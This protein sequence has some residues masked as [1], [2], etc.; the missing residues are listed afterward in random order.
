MPLQSSIANNFII[1]VLRKKDLHVWVTIGWK[2]ILW[3]Q[4]HF[5][6]NFENE[7]HKSQQG[8]YNATEIEVTGKLSPRI[9]IF[10]FSSFYEAM[11]DKWSIKWYIVFSYFQKKVF[12][13]SF[14]N[15]AFLSKC[16]CAGSC[17]L[18]FRMTGL[19]RFNDKFELFVFLKIHFIIMDF[20]WKGTN[21]AQKKAFLAGKEIDC[22]T[23]AF[24][25]DLFSCE[26]LSDG[27][28]SRL[29]LQIRT[30]GSIL[31][32]YSLFSDYCQM[33]IDRRQIEWPEKNFVFVT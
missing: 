10:L 32:S 27:L 1:L 26:Q 14:P 2:F 9:Y 21:I 11:L 22:A 4:I 30:D 25:F 31:F 5:N 33:L 23:I 17:N 19:L 15:L 16:Y 29:L 8:K 3:K 13:I 28:L 12:D 7:L 18:Y 20:F 6:D 24:W